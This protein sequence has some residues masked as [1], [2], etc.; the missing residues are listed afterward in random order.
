MADNDDLRL[1]I[2][3]LREKN[4]L[5]EDEHAAAIFKLRADLDAKLRLVVAEN[6]STRS[7]MEATAE[8]LAE[9]R[10]KNE[11]LNVQNRQLMIDMENLKIEHARK[12]VDIKQD[13]LSYYAKLPNGNFN[14]SA[15]IRH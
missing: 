4:S 12:E 10:K 6:V 14:N 2:T 7:R 9:E 15:I 8:E 1:Q 5:L 3:S 13:A 11:D